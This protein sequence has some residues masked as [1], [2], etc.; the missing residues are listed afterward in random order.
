MASRAV[1]AHEHVG[2]AL[3]R[4]GEHPL[5]IGIE[6]RSIASQL[7]DCEALNR[8]QGRRA[9]HRDM[10]ATAVGV[11][12][13]TT[14]ASQNSQID[15]TGREVALQPLELQI[16]VVTAGDD[17]ELHRLTFKTFKAVILAID[18]AGTK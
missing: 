7:I 11:G 4:Q 2:S 1:K 15:R 8:R 14:M 13:E 17:E 10:Q 5:G 3:G 16:K 12:L 18:Q 9:G 6:H